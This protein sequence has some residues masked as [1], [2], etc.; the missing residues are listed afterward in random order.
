MGPHWVP[1][2]LG[3]TVVSNPVQFNNVF[4]VLG[5]NGHKHILKIIFF[6]TRIN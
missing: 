2:G 3:G 5:F 1:F 6:N 4:L